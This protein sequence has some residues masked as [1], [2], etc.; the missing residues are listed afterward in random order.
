MLRY[1][2]RRLL[3]IVPTFI[4][5]TIV[6]FFIT[7]LVP[8]GPL[9]EAIRSHQMGAGPEEGRGGA[10]ARK[11]QSSLSLSAAQLAQLKKFYGLDQPVVPA[12]FAWL[13]KL[14][15]LDLGKSTRYGDPVLPMILER[16]PI[17]LYFGVA[18]LLITYMLSIPLGISKALKHRSLYDNLTSTLVFVGYAL[19]GYIVGI[20]LLSLFAFRLGWLPLGG[21]QSP[22]FDDMG[23]LEKLGDRASHMVLPLAAYVIGDFAVMTLMMKNNL[24]ENMA[25]DYIKTAVA[26]GR[27]FREAMWFHAFRNSLIPI[28]SGFGGIITVFLAGS[29]L[30]E[31]IFNIRGMG[32]LGYTALM[33]QDY[34]VVLG[35]LAIAAFASLLGNVLSDFFVSLVDPRIRF[36]Q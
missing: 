13:G 17:S 7:R 27:T 21:F 11:S 33:N 34:P 20:V 32:M 2:V 22:F 10:A 12:Y 29:F 31:N 16:V 24:M 8:G 4:G 3:L 23:L 1:F 15:R 26:K 28:A 14:A 36:G 30:V 25:A 19:P 18:S 9:E 35:T 5:I 6:V